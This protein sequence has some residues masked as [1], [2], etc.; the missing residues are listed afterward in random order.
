MAPSQRLWRALLACAAIALG[1][2]LLLRPFDSV[3]WAAAALA[4]GLII[5]G[6]AELF[7]DDVR[8]S[9]ARLA[10]AIVMPIV[11]VALLVWR[12]LSIF[13]IAVAAAVA[14]VA[15]AIGRWAHA[16]QRGRGWVADTLLGIGAVA[17]AVL[18]VS[19][20]GVS[21]FL[22]M[23][24]LGIALIWRGVGFG[25]A[26][27]R[28]PDR[29]PRTHLTLRTIGAVLAVVVTIPLVVATFAMRGTA[30]EP[31][32][33]YAADLPPDAA[34]GTLVK[35]EPTTEGVPDHARAWKILY[36]TIRDDRP[37]LAS[38]VVLAPTAPAAAPRPVIAWAHGT[39]GIAENCAPS[40]N[41]TPFAHIPGLTQVVA[42]GWVLVATDYVGMGTPGPSPYVI[43]D[44]EAR[45]V[46]DSIRAARRLPGIEM[47][48]QTVVWGHSQGGHAALWTELL[49]PSYAPDTGVIAT[50]AL[51]PAS[52]LSALATSLET[53]PA[54]ALLAAYVLDAYVAAYPDVHYDEYVKL[55][56]RLP[57]RGIAARCLWSRA[58]PVSLTEAL[59]LGTDFYRQDPTAGPLGERLAQN[60]PTDRL[61]VP[62]FIAQGLA[63]DVIA[64]SSQDAYAARQCGTGSTLDY[65]TYPGLGHMTLIDDDSPAVS[66]LLSWTTARFAGGAPTQTC[67]G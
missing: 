3:P 11:G 37:A 45:S 15:W 47:G 27:F 2:L 50:A 14:L 36:T 67:T 65:Q 61:P 52:D 30:P 1:V 53:M 51:A 35:F 33:F 34:P 43:G 5:G 20:P 21:V 28:S 31:G 60:T 48:T 23:S 39:S 8:A 64:P 25:L 22:V 56:A 63:D 59:I 29:A 9:R 55:Q 19:W 26:L 16:A 58:V 49:A 41:S 7:D 6:A 57:I 12:G 13:G 54:G 24:A 4:F 38:G 10:V 40:M 44:G 66:T 32:D 62:T 42:N 18:A 46:L 17:A